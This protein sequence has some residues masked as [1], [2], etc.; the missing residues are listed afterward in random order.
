MITLCKRDE[1]PWLSEVTGNLHTGGAASPL[2]PG[3]CVEQAIAMWVAKYWQVQVPLFVVMPDHVHLCVNVTHYLPEGLSRAMSW[4]MGRVSRIY[5]D[6]CIAK[7]E[8]DSCLAKA[9]TDSC[10]AR[11][12]TEGGGGVV[13]FFTKGFNDRIAYNDAHWAR[14]QI[15]IGDNPRR[16]LM[17]RAFPDIFLKNWIITVGSREFKARGNIM[18]LKN[19][20]LRVVRWSSKYTDLR[21]KEHQ[22]DC[23]R[24][25]DNG[26]VL[27]SPYIHPL[28][29]EIKMRAMNEG[30]GVV[31][32]CMN[33]F[34]ERF[35]PSGDE[36]EY[37]GT[38][39]LLLIAPMEHD[40]RRME[41]RRSM[42]MGMNALA[43]EIAAIDWLGGEGRI[44]PER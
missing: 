6:S 9:E 41:L 7:A 26:G 40:T 30:S 39:Q 25:I 28:E 2:A 27:I 20:E 33:G 35:Q 12:E 34:A 43:E 24:C 5:T 14:Q 1:I 36:F 13:T 32:I 11:A 4:F 8:T 19:P 17:K 22:E 23:R 15:Y 44:R 37:M 29:K 3:R 31:R 38:T 42:A 10:I 18:L 16:L 21:W